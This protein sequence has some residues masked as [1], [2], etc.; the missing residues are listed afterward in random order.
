MTTQLWIFPN[1][2][3]ID[4]RDS[5]Q[6][7]KKARES[8]TPQILSLGEHRLHFIGYPGEWRDYDV[9]VYEDRTVVKKTIRGHSLPEEIYTMPHFDRMVVIHDIIQ[10]ETKVFG[11]V[12]VT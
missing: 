6:E 7:I 3:T 1:G 11:V 9:L 8:V 4:I 2:W 5:Y 12:M 10:G